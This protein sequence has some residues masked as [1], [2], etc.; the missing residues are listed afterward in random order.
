M[1]G[2][3]WRRLVA[4]CLLAAGC[5]NAGAPPERLSNAAE[6][7]RGEAVSEGAGDL[8]KSDQGVDNPELLPLQ[9]DAAN[10]AKLTA[11]WVSTR[12]LADHDHRV[13]MERVLDRDLLA[14][15][16]PDE[17]FNGV[18]QPITKPPCSTGMPKVNDAYVWGLTRTKGSL[19]FGTVANTLCLVES[20]FLGA[21]SPQVTNEWV[22]EFGSSASK[23]GDFRAPNLFRYDLGAESLVPLNPPPGP[24]DLLRRSTIGFRSAGTAD[25][26]V[27]LAG[28]SALGGI[29]MFAFDASTG[30]LLGA[31]N[32]PAYGDIR[33][34]VVDQGVLY[35]GVLNSNVTSNTAPGGSVLRWRGHKSTNPTELFNFEEVG[36]LDTEASNLAVHQGRLYVTTWPLTFSGNPSGLTP[37]VAGLYRSPELGCNGLDGSDAEKWVKISSFSDYD[38]DPVAAA[39]TGGGAIASFDGKLYWGTMHV[40][41][42]ATEAAIALHNA[43]VI[44][45]DTNGNG[46]LDPDELLAT[47]L[48][49]HRSIEVFQ[50]DDLDTRKPKIKILYGERYLPRYDPEAKSYTIA[51]DAFH[52]N[53]KHER[54]VFGAS[55]VGNFFNAYTWSMT[56]FD[57]QLYLGTF[58]WSQVARVGIESL[59]SPTPDAAPFAPNTAE[60]LFMRHL[61]TRLPREG[62]DLF[63]FEGCD[64]PAEAESLTGLGNNRNYGIRT[65]ATDQ[66]HI[67]L[68]TA[69]PMNLDPKGGWELI[70]GERDPHAEPLFGNGMGVQKAVLDLGQGPVAK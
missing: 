40:P 43:H 2:G 38:P 45:L 19:W 26:V 13:E 7:P 70:R 46:T 54:P 57:H 50:G 36:H 5:S 17:C 30:A 65:M 21:A 3:W 58:D 24:A 59:L 55:G 33:T 9:G 60:G 53:P 8:F 64:S 63:R 67:Y 68:G 69:N 29:N 20:G 28:P 6:A 44:N 27:F 18:G 47:A 41:F 42:V 52:E 4:A 10:V 51:F 56:V 1:K 61:G 49:S 35:A 34:W 15:A 25:G 14:K 31:K 22:C 37:R 32:L 16:Q 66:K 39:T 48:G 62:A 12:F 23:T 11:F